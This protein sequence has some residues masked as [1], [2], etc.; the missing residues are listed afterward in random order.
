MGVHHEHFVATLAL[1]LWVRMSVTVSSKI[2]H[3]LKRFFKPLITL[4][5]PCSSV[6]VTLISA[7]CVGE[8]LGTE[9]H[10]KLNRGMGTHLQVNL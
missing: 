9:T 1:V 3:G 10:L 6:N 4:I 7:V 5:G 2:S 8:H